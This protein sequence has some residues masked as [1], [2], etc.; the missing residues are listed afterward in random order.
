MLM[1][2]KICDD[3]KPFLDSMTKLVEMEFQKFGIKVDIEA[4]VS[5]KDYIK[6]VHNTPGDIVFLDIDMPDL[7]GF[8]IAEQIM[9]ADTKPIIIFV[10]NQEHLVFRSFSYNPFWF[11]RKTHLEE[12][13]ELI[14]K[15]I[16]QIH[17]RKKSFSFDTGNQLV[18]IPLQEI[19]Y[20][21]SDN[22]YVILHSTM[23][24]YRYKARITEISKMLM[25]YYFARI[26]VGYLVNCRYITLIQ[27]SD[28]ILETG[29]TLPVSRNRI[30]EVQDQFIKYTRSIQP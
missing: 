29:E 23:T 18:S 24:T 4:F 30:K 21:E 26:H 22:H 1:Q 14:E 9:L 7:S 19:V 10:S 3:D 27:K 25:P 17:I 16:E 11:L 5:G 13:T 2:I 6:Q 15:A 12:L 8:E 28:L 20:F